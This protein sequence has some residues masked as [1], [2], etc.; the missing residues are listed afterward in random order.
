[1]CVICPGTMQYMSPER[2]NPQPPALG[3]SWPADVWSA[4]L[5]MLECAMGQ[6]PYQAMGEAVPFCFS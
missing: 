2:L 5:I 4:G 3:Y 6:H 1:M